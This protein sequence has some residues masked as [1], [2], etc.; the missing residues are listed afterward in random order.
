MNYISTRNQSVILSLSAAIQDGLAS[1]GGLYIPE[2][3]PVIDCSIFSSELSY[4][5][6]AFRLLKNFFKTDKLFESLATIC[7]RTF[8]FPVPLK[9]LADNTF[10]LEL[11]HGPTSSFKDFGAQ[12]LSECLNTLAN[13]KKTILVATSGDTGSAVASAFY[14]KLNYRVIIL[15]PDGQVSAKQEHQITCWDENIFAFAVDGTFD[16]CQQLVKSAFCDPVW[17]SSEGLSSANSINIGRLLPQVTYYA[18]NSLKF[19]RKNGDKPGFI[20]PS[21][22]LGN[23]TAAFWAKAMGF[24]IREI[25]LATNANQVIPDYLNSGNY[26]PRQSITTVA[27]AMDV[28]NPSNLERLDYLFDSFSSLKENVTAFSVNDEQI[29]KKIK[30][31]YEQYNYIICPHTAT[32]LHVRDQLDKL[33]WIVAATAAPC[34]FDELI[35]PIINI[36]IPVAPQLQRLLDRPNNIVKVGA[37]LEAIRKMIT[38]SL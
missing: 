25:V 11:F 7:E 31:V 13:C 12:F 23:A 27:N 24:P 16:Q 4:A 14:R 1:D 9:K 6:F 37:S 2:H 38:R 29:C 10:I 22:N 32:A 5:E 26:Q 18:Y 15:Y 28:G 33:P 36:K 8:H 30:R 3:I 19:Y 35:E 21:G 20:I 34:K 17:Q